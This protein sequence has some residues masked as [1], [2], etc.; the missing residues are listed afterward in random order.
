MSTAE[1]TSEDVKKETFD[2]D[3]NPKYFLRCHSKQR[4][5]A[6]DVQTQVSIFK[7]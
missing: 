3:F 6:A 1:D 5:D 2:I 7:N 4:K